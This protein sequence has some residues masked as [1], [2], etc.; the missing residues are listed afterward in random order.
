MRGW[1]LSSR[2]CSSRAEG[3]NQALWAVIMTAHVTGTST[4]K[5]DHLVRALGWIRDLEVEGVPDL[6][7]DRRRSRCLP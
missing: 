6:V 7:R 4:R 1:G 5:V 2:R 3:A